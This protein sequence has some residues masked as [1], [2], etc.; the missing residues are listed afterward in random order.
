MA[1]DKAGS[2]TAPAACKPLAHNKLIRPLTGLVLLGD[3]TPFY[4]LGAATKMAQF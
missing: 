2:F 4:N 3:S 1:G